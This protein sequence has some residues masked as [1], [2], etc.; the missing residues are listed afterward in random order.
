MVQ[1]ELPEQ[2][3]GQEQRRMGQLRPMLV[4]EERHM[5][6]AAVQQ[7]ALEQGHHKDS[8]FVG[9]QVGIP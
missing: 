6:L 9:C 4:L 5:D 2:Q 8:P 1:G 7:E 3:E